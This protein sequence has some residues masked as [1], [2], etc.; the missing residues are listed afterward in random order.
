MRPPPDEETT[1]V[2]GLKT[3]RQVYAFV[4]VVFVIWIGL[5]AVLTRIFM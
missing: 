4:L 2:P 5:L 1:G 3:W